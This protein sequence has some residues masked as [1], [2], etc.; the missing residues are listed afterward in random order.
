MAPVGELRDGFLRGLTVGFTS[1]GDADVRTA[2]WRARALGY[3]FLVAGLLVLLVRGPLA[4]GVAL[5]VVGAGHHDVHA[6]SD[7][8]TPGAQPPKE[9]IAPSLRHPDSRIHKLMH[10]WSGPSIGLSPI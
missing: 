2:R 8:E 5:V 7:R 10:A 6:L 4:V 3:P 9:R 1:D